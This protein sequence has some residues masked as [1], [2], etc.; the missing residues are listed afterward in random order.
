MTEC[1][2]FAAATFIASIKTSTLRMIAVGGERREEGAD[3][4]ESK[5]GKKE[6]N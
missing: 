5:L 2:L 1:S 4:N 6:T 3:I